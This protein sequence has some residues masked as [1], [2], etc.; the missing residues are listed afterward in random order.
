VVVPRRVWSAWCGGAV[1]ARAA[2]RNGG[3]CSTAVR[4]AATILAR[5][6]YR[7]MQSRRPPPDARH[8]KLC[9]VAKLHTHE[10]RH[11]CK[12]RGSGGGQHMS[13]AKLRFLDSSST[14]MSSYGIQENLKKRC[15]R[16][17]ERP[18]PALSRSLRGG[19]GDAAGLLAVG[20]AHICGCILTLDP[21]QIN[22]WSLQ[23][24]NC[25]SPWADQRVTTSPR[26]LAGCLITS[27][28]RISSNKNYWIRLR[29]F[30]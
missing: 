3:C 26:S 18:Q 4:T 20:L 5:F 1:A 19:D 16:C 13:T 22:R 2:P 15:F 28:E 12:A 30:F 14:A 7:A 25:D 24:R 10:P 9:F 17:R 8:A 29:R 21:L 27:L 6:Q 23:D 11:L